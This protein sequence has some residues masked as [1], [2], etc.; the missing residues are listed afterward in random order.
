ML[1]RMM[2][3]AALL[4]S[5]WGFVASA[6]TQPPLL[7]RDP[8][9][10]RTQIAFSYGGYIWTTNRDGSH[11]QQLTKGGEESKP[12]FSP[13]GSQIAFSANF[14]G[15][16]GV[17]VMPSAGGKPRRL[18]YNPADRS[19]MGWTP[20]GR[21]I[22]FTSNRAAFNGRVEQLFTV[23]ASGGPVTPVPLVTATWA[24]YSPDGTR[25]AYV[26]RMVGIAARKRYRGGNTLPIWI[27]NLSDSSIQTSIPRDNSNDFNPMWVGDII[28]FLSDRNGPVT[29]FAYDTRSR[30]VTQVIENHSLDMKSA[31]A[32]SDAI[33]YEQFGYL[34]IVDL[35]S[36]KEHIIDVRVPTDLPATRPRLRKIEAQMIHSADVAPDG[37][38][39]FSARGEVFS[40]DPSAQHAVDLT[41]TTDV[42]ER[43]ATWSPDGSSI[44]YLSDAS[45]EWALHIRGASGKGPVNAIDLGAPPNYFF[46]PQWSP[47]SRKILYTDK[48]LN[49]WYVDL[50]AKQPVRVD[51]D[52]FASANDLINPSWSPDSRWIVY[53][54]QTKSFMHTLRAFSLEQGKSFQLT[55]GMSDATH[56]V[57]DKSGQYLYFAASTDDGLTLGF[58]DMSGVVHPATRTVY[59][60]ILRKAGVSPIQAAPSAF[61][62]GTSASAHVD[63]DLDNLD[64]RIV[65]LPAPA[66]NYSA[67]L[68]GR[69]GELYL[70][71]DAFAPAYYVDAAAAAGP[72]QKVHKL[73]LKTGK[74]Q[75]LLDGVEAFYLSSDAERALYSRHGDWLVA[76]AANPSDSPTTPSID[77]MQ[78]QIDP[79]AEW[80]HMFYQTWRDERDFFY[81][82]G[83][84]GV[85]IAAIEKRYAPYLDNLSS[86]NDLNYL[87]AEMLGELSNS[88]IAPLGGDIPPSKHTPVGMLG[89]DYEIKDGRY[90]FSRIFHA[91][92][93]TPGMSAPLTQPGVSVNVGDYLLAVN[94]RNVDGTID[95]Y[96]YFENTA[97]KST[98]IKVGAHADGSDAREMIIVPIGDERDLRR[99][100]WIEGNQ[101]KVDELSG[102]RIAYIFLPNTH[103]DGY[104]AFNRYY[105]A[106]IG[107]EAAII[108]ERYNG[109]GSIADYMIDYMKRPLLNYWSTRDGGVR[110][111]P[112]EALFGPKVLLTDSNTLSGGDA[113]AYM[114]R[115]SGIGPLVGTRTYGA[116]NS[117]YNGP[118]DFLDGAFPATPDWAFY[119]PDGSWGTVE[120]DGVAPDFDVEEDPQAARQG[121]DSQLEKAV[122]V[123]LDLLKKSPATVPPDHAPYPNYHKNGQ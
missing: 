74:I 106:Q 89:A 82:P 122:A 79:R 43:D 108:D 59:A 115:S 32:A 109:G 33:V 34:H 117:Y 118:N 121:R 96:G 8:T 64:Q 30:Q 10:S 29:L 23:P 44:A 114:F 101:R 69:P 18:M 35:R 51:T 86:R 100:A 14:D 91:D 47:D 5:G 6:S 123:T 60:M 93:W 38:T 50:T 39:L 27:A 11:L 61:Q 81:D 65:A 25:L 12:V 88:H 57:F 85:D 20:D 97:D 76:S 37:S 78:A 22:L 99:F 73:D 31:A 119:M 4:M 24:A 26:P 7:L 84:H 55:D 13:D 105:F 63:I 95:L 102:G 21:S 28:Y 58:N 40:F 56:P 107:K 46:A 70:I 110:S 72:F 48:R 68:A 2:T 1:K 104:K 116:L 54:K 83:L 19:T 17:Y 16:G 42:V 67:L 113:L 15:T 62:P 3:V 80:R 75:Q 112:M 52:L 103:A 98:T 111:E 36:G 92:T 77:H 90:V 94:G 71:E 53:C 66:R 41:N 45:G 9:L 49:V 87:F 120:S